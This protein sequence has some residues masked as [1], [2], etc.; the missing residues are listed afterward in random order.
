MHF[1][2]TLLI[3]ALKIRFNFQIDVQCA[4]KAIYKITDEML[5]TFDIWAHLSNIKGFENDGAWV[6]W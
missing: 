2:A 6:A 3:L 5:I 4:E 1:A